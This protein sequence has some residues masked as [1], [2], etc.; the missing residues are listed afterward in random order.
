MSPVKLNRN[1]QRVGCAATPRLTREMRD[2]RRLL[3]GPRA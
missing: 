1:G 2:R 3:D